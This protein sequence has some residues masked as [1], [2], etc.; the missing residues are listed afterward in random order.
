M[1]SVSIGRLK[2][3]TREGPDEVIQPPHGGQP[4]APNKHQ[5][6]QQALRPPLLPGQQ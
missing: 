1:E 5:R 4:A 6:S 2:S 3:H